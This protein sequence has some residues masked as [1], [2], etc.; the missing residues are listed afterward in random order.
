MSTSEP[1]VVPAPRRR[2]RRWLVLGVLLLL[3]A[4]VGVVLY[5]QASRSADRELRE[6][7]A[8]IDRRDPGWR[9][10]DLEA[11]RPAI[12]DEQN[13][14]LQVLEARRLLPSPWP[15]MPPQ[16]D[17]DSD[18]GPTLDRLL[19][20]LEPQHQLNDEQLRVLRSELQAAQPALQK[21]E[22]LVNF[23]E[24]RYPITW[25]L[26][27][28][29]SNSEVVQ[30][31][32]AVAR[33]LQLEALRRA[34]DGDADGACRL[35]RSLINTGRSIG[36]EY[37]LITMLV[38]TSLLAVA[39][40]TLER[41]LAQGE[42]GE[43][44]LA[45]VQRALEREEQETPA[46]TAAAFRG[47]RA[48]GHRM[49]EAIERGD[50]SLSALSTP[51]TLGERASDILNA[52]VVRH[53]HVVYLRYMTE[54]AE[55][56]QAPSPDRAARL[57]DM[58]G[59]MERNARHEWLATLLVVSS[60]KTPSVQSRRLAQLRCAVVA[61]ALERCRRAE[62]R[63]PATLDALAPRYLRGVPADP[64][65]GQPLRYRRLDDGVVVY[66]VGPD[67]T[68]DGGTI[69]REQPL[70]EGTDLGFRLWDAARRR[71]PAPPPPPPPAEEK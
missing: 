29:S 23:P 61:L 3:P 68:D 22:G 38:R 56:A 12:P 66:S 36:P 25:K 41:T 35:E 70:R 44:I 52:G 10:E 62:G 30:Q 5:V 18:E 15:S 65:D 48:L 32:R 60:D 20:G 34:Q 9:F 46:L 13:G 21:A 24:G 17:L 42:P 47:E 37:T 8:D 7:L 51:P 33:L 40:S 49:L 28:I 45:A 58:L 50:L 4:G 16:K 19:K 69:D 57:R 31:C 55:A 11:K 27:Y 26:E 43:E 63:W 6:A 2:R 53:S 59:A 67:R 71:Q 1:P 54:A 39:T 14:A 64:F